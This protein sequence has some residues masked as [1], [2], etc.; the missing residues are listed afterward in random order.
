MPPPKSGRKLTPRQSETLRLWIEQGAEWEKHWA[1]QP[2]R[3]RPL[4]TV[5]NK[6]WP[7][8]P[9]D[10]FILAK[11]ESEGLPP[12]AEARRETLL[13]RVSLDLT[14]LPPT[15]AEVDAFLKDQAPRAYESVVERLLHSPRFGERMVLDWL[16]AARYADTNGYQTDG[17]R[18]MWPWRDWVIEAFNKNMPFDQF[19]VEQIA[20]DMLPNATTAQKIASGF[21]RNHMLN[22]EGGRI[23]EE[24]RVDYVVDRVDTTATV[25][26]G[27]TAG[28]A[29]CHDHKYDP[30]SQKEYYRLYAYFNNVNET[31]GVDRRNSTAAPTLELPTEE[32]KQKT[33]ALEKAL[34]AVE[35]RAKTLQN[36]LLPGLDA[37]IKTAATDKLPEPGVPHSR[38]TNRNAAPHKT[39]P[40][41]PRISI[42]SPSTE[43]SRKKSSKRRRRWQPSKTACSLPW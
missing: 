34:A 25:W 41:V 5:R 26:L 19:T 28:C 30:I 1:L 31:G 20:G 11:I 10:H 4:P 32:Q 40:F 21:H 42:A 8:N 2:P 33:A 9:I 15:L 24:S 38:L 29:R 12:A 23:A 13:R 17:T 39:R 6:A 22:G 35:G 16:D 43:A 14:G 7:R 18:A 36:K 27:L 37:W 3:E